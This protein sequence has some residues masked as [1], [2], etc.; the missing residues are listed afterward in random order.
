MESSWVGSSWQKGREWDWFPTSLPVTFKEKKADRWLCTFQRAQ[1]FLNR[2]FTLKF[3]FSQSSLNICTKGNMNI[4]SKKRILFYITNIYTA[5][6]QSLNAPLT[7]WASWICDL[8]L[9]FWMKLSS[10]KFPPPA[11]FWQK[12]KIVW[13]SPFFIPFPPLFFHKTLRYVSFM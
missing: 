13:R 3:C 9:S 12:R 10:R 11:H 5:Y 1:H 7:D 4:S 8:K 6:W 2:Q